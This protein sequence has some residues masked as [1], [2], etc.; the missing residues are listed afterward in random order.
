MLTDTAMQRNTPPS[1]SLFILET[2]VPRVLRLNFI[3]TESSW[4]KK[5]KKNLQNKTNV[6]KQPN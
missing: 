6:K 5:K 2:F 1:L 3:F 4:M